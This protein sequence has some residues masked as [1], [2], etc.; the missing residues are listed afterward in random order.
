MHRAEGTWLE[1]APDLGSHLHR[2]PHASVPS[3]VRQ[4]NASTESCEAENR[5][6]IINEGHP[7]LLGECTENT[8]AAVFQD[9][10]SVGS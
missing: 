5:I 1:G 8:V 4:E 6:E 10:K 2:P 7:V 9:L 3:F